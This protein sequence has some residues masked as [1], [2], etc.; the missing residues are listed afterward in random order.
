VVHCWNQWEKQRQ[1]NHLVE[2][3]CSTKSNVRFLDVTAAMLDS[4]GKPLRDLFKWDGLH[5]SAECYAL[6]TSIIRPV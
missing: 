4:R 6:W 3:F 2:E 5:P 1:T